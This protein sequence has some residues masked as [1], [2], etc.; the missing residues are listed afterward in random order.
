MGRVHFASSD[1]T[2]CI[3]GRFHQ[4]SKGDM[5]ALKSA[6]VVKVPVPGGGTATCILSWDVGV[7]L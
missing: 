7:R 1:L 2:A 5:A 6:G 4:G 3:Q